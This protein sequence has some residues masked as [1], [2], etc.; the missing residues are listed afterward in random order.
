MSKKTL[1]E[2]EKPLTE[3][4]EQEKETEEPLAP[5]ETPAEAGPRPEPSSRAQAEG[6]AGALFC[7]SRTRKNLARWWSSRTCSAPAK[8]ETSPVLSTVEGFATPEENFLWYQ[9]TRDKEASKRRTRLNFKSLKVPWT[10][11]SN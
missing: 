2:V 8:R 9:V 4:A 1:K 10:F 7:A 5:E 6:L 11:Y 3:E